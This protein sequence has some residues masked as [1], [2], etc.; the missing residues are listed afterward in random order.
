MSKKYQLPF[1]RMESFVHST[2][3]EELATCA[4]FVGD[5]ISSFGDCPI[6]AIDVYTTLA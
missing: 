1:S 5:R 6:Y 4:E 2:Q 3:Y